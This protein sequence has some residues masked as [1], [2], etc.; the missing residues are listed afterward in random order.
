M[1][2]VQTFIDPGDVDWQTIDSL[3]GVKLMPLAQPVPEGSIHRAR[4]R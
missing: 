4:I 1:A 2:A 3:P